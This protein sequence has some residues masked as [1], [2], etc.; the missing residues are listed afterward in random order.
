MVYLDYRATTPVEKDVLESFNTVDGSVDV[1]N[2]D[3]II[4]DLSLV[5]NKDGI[6]TFSVDDINSL[7]LEL[8]YKD[9]SRVVK[10]V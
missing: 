4:D 9:K 10:L 1:L 6:V 3:L 8:D 2:P 7:F 5:S